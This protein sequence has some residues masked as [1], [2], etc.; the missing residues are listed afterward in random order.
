MKKSIFVAAIIAAAC[1]GVALAGDAKQ[2][3]KTTQV[4]TIKATRMS[5]A[6]MDKV[7]ASP[8]I[9]MRRTLAATLARVIYSSANLS[10]SPVS[11]AGLSICALYLLLGFLS[12]GRV[13]SRASA[14]WP[15][16]ARL[17]LHSSLRR[18]DLVP[19]GRG[20]R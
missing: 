17:E 6:E 10:Q 11:T 12:L 3:Q 8:S 14:A 1:S 9:S 7:A 20:L 4:P 15:L 19:P 16:I 18:H 2:I 5:D 13:S